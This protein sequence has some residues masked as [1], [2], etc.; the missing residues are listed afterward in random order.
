MNDSLCGNSKHFDYIREWIIKQVGKTNQKL[1]LDSFLLIAGK[2][3]IGK[4]FSIKKICNDIGLHIIYLST[5]NCSSSAEISDHIVKNTTSS[6]LQVL[7]NDTRKKIIIIDEFESMMAIDRTINS[8]LFNILC[9]KKYKMVPIIC[10]S[11]VEMIK[12]L[13]IMKKK[14]EIIELECPTSPQIVCLLKNL[15]PDISHDVISSVVEKSQNNVSQCIQCMSSDMHIPFDNVDE[16]LN[17]N[18]LYDEDFKRED[19]VNLL[20]TD[21]WLIPL[22]F[23]ENLIMEMKNRKM[24]IKQSCQYYHFFINRL[25]F[26]DQLMHNNAIEIACEYLTSA[27]YPL[28]ECPLKK[29]VKSYVSGFTKILSYLSLQKKYAKKSYS[30]QFPLY[31]I[32]NYHINIVG[33]NNIFFN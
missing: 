15:Y 26:F 27:M 6:M 28:S 10:I 19:I 13:G 32:G 12:K 30:S 22:R 17:M 1:S 11:S 21:P 33:R 29:N 7:T 23:H 16:I 24:T 14:C 5:T 31:Q 8:T 9:E 18:L 3:G 2:S 4:T 20:A 25:I